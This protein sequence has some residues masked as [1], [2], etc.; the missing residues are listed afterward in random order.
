MA[1]AGYP[2]RNRY[3]SMT[4]SGQ[5]RMYG[6]LC[7][8]QPATDKTI[9][10]K[11][12]DSTSDARASHEKR[13]TRKRN[14]SPHRGLRAGHIR[15]LHEIIMNMTRNGKEGDDSEFVLDSGASI[16]LIKRNTWSGKLLNRHK[17]MIRD[18]V[19]KRHTADD[20]P[21]ASQDPRRPIP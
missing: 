16:H 2:K 4:H 17:V 13:Q 11:Y 21:N 18:A 19:G 6:A 12:S 1:M 20:T 3:D 14:R 9:H 7:Y 15:K 8:G 5:R 10:D